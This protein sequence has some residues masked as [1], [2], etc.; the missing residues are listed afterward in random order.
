MRRVLAIVT[1]LAACSPTA[2]RY[3]NRAG[4]AVAESSIACDWGDTRWSAS[5]GWATQ[6]ERN[7]IMGST[8]SVA[9]VDMYMAGSA[10][11]VAAAWAALPERWRFIAWGS[12]L[13]V[14]A[15]AIAHNA[16]TTP[17]CGAL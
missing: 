17:I 9:T 12:A 2:L 11:A 16:R 5:R 15:D 4:L 8:P 14:Q 6:H 1:L 7:M 10:A 13:I 3:V